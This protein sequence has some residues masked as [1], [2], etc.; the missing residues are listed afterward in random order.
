MKSNENQSIYNINWQVG[1]S[2]ISRFS[3]QKSI[4]IM[5]TIQPCFLTLQITE[6]IKKWS[7]LV[8]KGGPEIHQKSSKILPGTFQGSLECIC[9]PLDHQNGAKMVPRTSKLSD[10]RTLKGDKVNNIQWQIMSQKGVYFKQCSIDFNP[11]NPSN[12]AYP[13]NLQISSQLVTR[14]AGGRG[15]ALR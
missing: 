9:V 1:T 7:K 5:S 11:G 4:K 6:N 13:C 2:E 12:P 10:S 15:E 14:G 3:I 8:S